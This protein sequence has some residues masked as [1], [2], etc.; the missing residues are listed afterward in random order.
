VDS[1]MNVNLDVDTI[2]DTDTIFDTDEFA[3]HVCHA[4]NHS[5][6]LFCVMF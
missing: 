1:D 4:G 5:Q 6:L 3:V 2:P